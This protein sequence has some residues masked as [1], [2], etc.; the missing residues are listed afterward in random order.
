MHKAGKQFFD[1]IES[2]RRSEA[3]K[4]AE[5][6]LGLEGSSTE[7]SLERVQ[8]EER[9]AELFHL[10]EIRRREVFYSQKADED[11]KWQ[12]PLEDTMPLHAL[13]FSMRN[14]IKTIILFENLQLNWSWSIW[15]NVYYAALFKNTAKIFWGNSPLPPPSPQILRSGRD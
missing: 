6:E 10:Y 3:E 4:Q 1:D 5:D 13:V 12:W 7:A 11:W 15:F 14:F 2:Q 9:L 8:L